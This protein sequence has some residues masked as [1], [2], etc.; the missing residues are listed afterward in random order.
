[1]HKQNPEDTGT[2]ST[3]AG[4][5]QAA[6]KT[7]GRT[8]RGADLVVKINTR[9]TTRLIETG[10]QAF[11]ALEKPGHDV[12]LADLKVRWVTCVQ[13]LLAARFKAG[14]GYPVIEG[15]NVPKFYGAV[16]AKS[17]DQVAIEKLEARLAKL[18][19][20]VRSK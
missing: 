4:A 12:N 3:D 16:S 8:K 14:S 5:V 19:A 7:V 13:D 20:K 9:L 15:V 2:Q 11:L 6:G 10:H 1:M 18:K 17:K